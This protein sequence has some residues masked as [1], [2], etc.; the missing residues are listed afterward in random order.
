MRSVFV[1]Y[2][3]SCENLFLKVL[4]C[5]NGIFFIFGKKDI[6]YYVL[7]YSKLKIENNNML[8]LPDVVN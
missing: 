7:L 1:L 4:L 2:V 3:G 6:L 8:F 5:R